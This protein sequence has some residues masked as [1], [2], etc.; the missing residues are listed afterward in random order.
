MT[1]CR[2]SNV[3][4]DIITLTSRLPR[5]RGGKEGLLAQETGVCSLDQKD[6]LE[7]GT[8]THSRILAKGLP[9]TEEP[10]VLQSMGSQEV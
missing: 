3:K 10:G 9:W 2:K 6:P 1:L 8:A 5:W 7:E 4:G